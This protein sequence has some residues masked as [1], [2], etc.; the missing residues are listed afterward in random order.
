MLTDKNES[1]TPEEFRALRDIK[2][3]RASLLTRKIPSAIKAKLIKQG[4]AT[5]QKSLFGGISLTVKGE[6]RLKTGK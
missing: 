5:E 1:L 6:Q 2:G 3:Q 4:F